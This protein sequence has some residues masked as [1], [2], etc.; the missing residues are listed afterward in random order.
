MRKGVLGL[1]LVLFLSLTPAYSATPPKAGSTCSKQGITKTYKGKTFKCKKAKGK[2]LWSKGKV[3]KQ[4]APVQ[5]PTTTQI[6]VPL[7]NS[8][9]DPVSLCKIRDRSNFDPGVN[10]AYS[11]G[12]FVE[13]N[14]PVPATGEVTWYLVP[15]DFQDL[16]G[17]EDWRKRVDSQMKNLTRFYEQVSYGKLR[18]KWKVYENWIT[19]PDKVAKYRIEHSGDYDTTEN[20]WKSAISEVDKYIDFTN[21]QTINFVLPK[22]QKSV[23]ESAQGFPW[24]GDIR[25]YFSEES[26]FASFTILGNYFESP[27]RS[28]WSYWAHEY[29]HVLGIPHLGGSRWSYSFQPY[30][31]M[32]NQDIGREISGWSRFAV[33]RW[34]EDEWVYCKLSQNVEVELVHIAPINSIGNQIKLVIIPINETK[35]LVLES[36]RRDINSELSQNLQEISYISSTYPLY[37]ANPIRDGVFVYV[38]DSSLGHIEEYLHLTTSNENPILAAGDSI[39]YLGVKISVLEVGK[40]DKVLISHNR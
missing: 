32:G 23:L 29:G 13:I 10:N 11:F 15:I 19:L 2:L 38:Y 1:S 39:E 33:T 36:R 16:K 14:P 30:D 37:A 40:I 8:I 6:Q 24:T 12:G 25:N 28:Y 5:S 7:Q 3:V 9:S 4:A 34:I 20:F 31:L 21:I 22:N 26:K 17:E 18:I 35:T 27:G